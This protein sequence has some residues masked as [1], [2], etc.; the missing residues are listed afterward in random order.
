MTVT[1]IQTRSVIALAAAIELL[2]G[3]TIYA[4]PRVFTESLYSHL[5]LRFP[6][7]TVALIACGLVLVVDL[8]YGMPTWLRRLLAVPA[9]FPLAVVA[10]GL[11]PTGAWL[12]VV[13]HLGLA[14][15]VVI[16]P[17]LSNAAGP[18]TGQPGHDL[19]LLTIALIEG[20]IGT[21]MLLRPDPFWAPSLAPLRAAMPVL[22]V[23]S[24][25]SM[26][27]LL[28]LF[29]KP[30]G[31]K[32]YTA[33]LRGIGS[34]LPLVLIASF[35]VAGKWAGI[36][37][38]T[39]VMPLLIGPA[40]LSIWSRSGAA[41][42][43]PDRGW[44]D[45]LFPVAERNLE[46]FNWALVLVV[47][48]LEVMAG[49]SYVFATTAPRWFV[50]VVSIYT[51]CIYWALPRLG[52]F[53]VRLEC[54][55]A[56]LT[57]GLGI[58]M[59]DPAPAGRAFLPLVGG[60][61]LVAARM[62]GWPGGIR[63]LLLMLVTIVGSDFMLHRTLRQSF[64]FDA[65]HWIHEAVLMIGTGI[66]TRMAVVQR[67]AVRSLYETQR[68][69][70]RQV[71]QLAMVDRINRSI[72]SSLELDEILQTAVHEL[73][74]A[75]DVD[76]CYIIPWG[77]NPDGPPTTY[78]YV[79]EGV[80]PI[81]GSTGFN[82]PISAIA[83][84]RGE[85]LAI[86]DLAVAELDHAVVD[87]RKLLLSYGV[88]S[89]LAVP[90]SAGA[91]LKAVLSMHACDSPRFWTDE[92]IHFVSAIAS[93]VAVALTHA[94]HHRS[95]EESHAHLLEAH[96]ALQSKDDE[97]AWQQEELLAQHE[98]LKYLADYDSLTS[99]FNRRRFQEELEKHLAEARLNGTAFALL[100]MDFDQFKFVND[101]LGHQA[102]DELL[103][104]ISTLL[105]DLLQETAIISRLGG[106]EFALILPGAGHDRAERTAQEIVQAVRESVHSIGGHPVGIT[107][108]IG[109]VLYPDNGKTAEELLALADQAMYQVKEGGRN[110]YR[111]YRP[112]AERDSTVGTRL[113]WERRIRSALEEDRFELHFQPVLDLEQGRVVQYE[114]LLRMVDDDGSL[115]RPRAFVDVAESFGLIHSIDR[116][117][118]RHAIGAIA[119]KRE[120]HPQLV[121]AVNLSGKAFSDPDLLALI[122]TELAQSGVGA[123]QLVLEITETAAIRDFDRA[124]QFI[125][126]L[127]EM[128]CRFSLDDF[129]V[130][131]AS[132]NYLKHLPVDF[133]KIDGS[134]IEH[135]A[136]NQGDRQLVQAIVAA[137]HALGK[138]T[139]AESVCD[140]E[141]VR[142]LK[143][144]G[145]TCI[146]GNYLAAAS[147]LLQPAV[148]MPE[149]L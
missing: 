108:S 61:P 88:R 138:Q 34:I 137:A 30:S 87:H 3:M 125:V 58:L 55:V 97:L 63:S 143:R 39:A 133:V 74:T 12:G 48:L 72:R 73:G 121:L 110:H 45:P 101:T 93:Q 1:R 5:I 104:G 66:G 78:E 91:E 50:A 85:A 42:R 100:F 46:L 22:G 17:W 122:R 115:I 80:E 83:A 26:A 112:E 43:T 130:G 53:P 136:G 82:T 65:A 56:V 27:G 52:S 20:A 120:S 117:V 9:A 18:E 86:S 51:A 106:D 35:I 59:T 114:V 16:A 148:P 19:L 79:R 62:N 105:T 14:G 109:V 145:V 25:V 89:M 6:F 40:L 123:G 84:A 107:V 11:A 57:L 54:H 60:M 24:L 77:R 96:E 139:I 4:F 81:A 44:Q 49:D 129:G 135:L 132:F 8:R 13:A 144:F 102:G 111:V 32:L 10:I 36:M 47:I 94:G 126:A 128:G 95:L 142:I 64:T 98:A 113:N 68:K 15:A 147:P 69:S 92:E 67:A 140:P 99:L 33:C 38:V 119:R 31:S 146:Q 28:T 75:M 116:W 23:L 134:F 90:V 124:R 41:R 29:F 103:R 118:V 71:R 149:G 127:R 2:S 37:W 7:L 70:D 141:S 76:R 21:A 131:F